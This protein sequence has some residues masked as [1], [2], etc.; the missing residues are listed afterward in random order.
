MVS[1]VQY[2]CWSSCWHLHRFYP[3]WFL[4]QV[5]VILKKKFNFHFTFP[6]VV[7]GQAFASGMVPPWPAAAPFPA[8]FPTGI[9]PPG[10][11]A[12]G[13]QQ[14]APM[15]FPRSQGPQVLQAPQAP[16][17]GPRHMEMPQVSSPQQG[18]AKAAAGGV[19][20]ENG[21]W[22]SGLS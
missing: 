15:A 6:A 17:G 9:W 22:F 21:G 3:I 11:Q 16:Q 4:A 14:G 5:K 20:G 19:Q 10:V 7:P 18:M 12:P 13:R 8:S 2:A 1:L